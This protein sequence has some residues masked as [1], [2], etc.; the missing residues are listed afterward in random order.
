[1][2]PAPSERHPDLLHVLAH[3]PGER[4]VPSDDL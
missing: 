2:N 1:M 3:P 4:C